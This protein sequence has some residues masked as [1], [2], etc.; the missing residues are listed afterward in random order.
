MRATRENTVGTVSSMRESGSR[1]AAG[2]PPLRPGL[3]FLLAKRWVG[4]PAFGVWAGL[5]LAG[6]VRVSLTAANRVDW[7]TATSQNPQTECFVANFTSTLSRSNRSYRYGT[8]SG[9][10]AWAIRYPARCLGLLQQTPTL[11]CFIV[12]GPTAGF[13]INRFASLRVKN[14]RTT[15]LFPAAGGTI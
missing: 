5:A 13:K 7:R 14:I 11:R 6:P 2:Q 15:F 9:L 8:V 10:R 4:L 12:V 3:G 1:Y